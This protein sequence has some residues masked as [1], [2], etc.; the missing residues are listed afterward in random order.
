VS[1]VDL[2]SQSDV[3]WRT[4]KRP[5]RPLADVRLRIERVAPTSIRFA[6]PESSPSLQQLEPERERRH[7]VVTLPP[8]STWGLV[9]ISD[10]EVV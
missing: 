3:L 2:S 1:L 7:D 4:P 6:S 9:W 10:E 8:F 5:P